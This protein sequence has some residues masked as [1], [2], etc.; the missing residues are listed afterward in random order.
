MCYTAAMKL[1]QL[2]AGIN[3][4]SALLLSGALACS[5]FIRPEPQTAAEREQLSVCDAGCRDDYDPCVAGC[6]Y[7]DGGT[8][9][10]GCEQTYAKCFR[11]CEQAVQ[12]RRTEPG[13]DN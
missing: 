7:D 5:H 12:Q 8:C 10:W 3:V 13:Q 9:A 4:L 6:T 11:K 2:P 1:A